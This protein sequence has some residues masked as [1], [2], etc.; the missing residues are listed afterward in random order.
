MV[1][2]Y[3]DFQF[4][5]INER[6]HIN[7]EVDEYSDEIYDFMKKSKSKEFIFVDLPPKLNINKLII[8]L[9]KLPPG[10]GGQ[11]DLNKSEQLKS[12]WVIYINLKE[13][14]SLYH[15]KHE[16]NHALRLTLIGKDKMIKN[17]NFINAKNIFGLNKNDEIN[18]FFYLL[19]LSNDEEINAKV[20]ETKGLIQEVM[21]KWEVKKISKNDFIYIIQGSDAYRQANEL[22]NYNTDKIFKDWSQNNINKL[23]YI[24][25]ENKSELD[26]IHSSSF[27]KIKLI[28]KM[29][30]DVFINKTNFEIED[31]HI[32][33]PKKD[34][35][36]Y[37]SWIPSQGE[38]LKRNL[39]SLYEHYQ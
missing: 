21:E 19:Y 30:K 6:L 5:I 38:K 23:F 25:E 36:F 17:L 33:K 16:L 35:K 27:S 37:D 12:G 32:Y 39:Y 20:I 28:I 29:F 22:I 24:L 26:K 7:K 14:F 2:N 13:D 34:K 1:L 11:L 9:K 8:K 4:Q 10:N 18:Y 31:R 15:L 3:K